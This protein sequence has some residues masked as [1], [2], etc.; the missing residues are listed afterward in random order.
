[1][2]IM[3]SKD[4]KELIVSCKCGC[5]DTIH[6]KVDDM[7][8]DADY[9]AFMTYLNGSWYRCQDDTVLKTIGRK[10]KKIWAIICNKDYYYS[11]IVM[12]CDDFKQLKEYL[13][14]EKPACTILD[15]SLS[16]KDRKQLFLKKE[17]VIHMDAFAW[18]HQFGPAHYYQMMKRMLRDL[19]ECG[20]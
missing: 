8:K 10:L 17:P 7:D 5:Q 20:K 16:R 3:M 11:D 9:Y 19:R 13:L 12:S 4:K 15:P 1:M 6:I 18:K 14:N 2:A